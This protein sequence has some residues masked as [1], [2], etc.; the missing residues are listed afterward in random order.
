MFSYFYVI[1]YVGYLLKS[2]CNCIFYVLI[3]MWNFYL[4]YLSVK[5]VLIIYFGGYGFGIKV[6]FYCNGV[7]KNYS[8]DL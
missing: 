6:I 4:S 3:N 7:K 2:G 8:F 1:F 5:I